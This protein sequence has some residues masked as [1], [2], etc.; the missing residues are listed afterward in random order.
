MKHKSSAIFSRWFTLTEM[1]IVISVFAILIALL[2]PSLKKA[3]TKARIIT[4]LTNLK[5]T[6]TGFSLYAE[7]HQNYLTVGLDGSRGLNWMDQIHNYLASNSSQSLTP[8]EM[9]SYTIPVDKGL[10]TFFCPSESRNYTTFLAGTWHPCFTYVMPMTGNLWSSGP[11][12]TM[13]YIGPSYGGA[14]DSI[15]PVAPVTPWNLNSLSRPDQ[16]ALLAENA[17]LA[18]VTNEMSI[19][20]G[21][22]GGGISSVPQSPE[23]MALHNFSLNYLFVDGHTANIDAF[24][25]TQWGTGTMSA[26]NGIYSVAPND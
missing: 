13:K 12:M 5:S 15:P 23:T 19:N 16:I 11:S 17:R 25:P 21:G 18:T 24:D 7:D 8:A 22:F 20:Q 6:A 14:L 3:L 9:S 10:N 2:V 26:P 1:L 4:C